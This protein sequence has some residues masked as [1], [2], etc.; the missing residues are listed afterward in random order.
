MEAIAAAASAS[1]V[2]LLDSHG[3]PDHNRLVVTA[4]GTAPDDLADA[5]L[6]AVSEAVRRIDLRTHGGV[7]PRVGAADVVP[8]VPLDGT[9]MVACVELA[10]TLGERI[11]R[12]LH[13]PVYLYGEAARRREAVR[14]ASIRGG[15][16]EPD[17]GGPALHPSAGAV[18][19]GARKPLVAYN[20][21]LPGATRDDAAELARAVRAS[22]GG[23]QG[24]QALAFV[25]GD[26]T[27][28][29]SMN[30]VD[31]DAA[32][33]ALVLEAVRRLAAELGIDFGGEE[34][35]GLCPAPVATP[36]ASSRLL[37][38]RLAASAAKLAAA[39]CR[40]RGSRELALLA[41]RLD[42]EALELSALEA[43]PEAM[44]A[45]AERA[46]AL[47]RLLGAAGVD[48]PEISRLLRA[49]ATGLRAAVPANLHADR[50]AALDRWLAL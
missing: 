25:L 45:G 28:Q 24:V 7:H 9:P 21:L 1:H 30:L 43:T 16:L 19:V 17:L 33:P 32:P 49:A 35:V 2:H 38:G 23:L 36:A 18:C 11:W 41:E 20:V 50:V 26:G 27:A 13:V 29:L 39:E 47:I 40:R 46:A 42:N 37:E 3:D 31:L 5:L 4:A 12:E 34:V 6:R 10:R 8:I 44:L 14:L 22:S 48:K 15:A